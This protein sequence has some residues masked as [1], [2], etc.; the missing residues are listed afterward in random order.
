M[1]REESYLKILGFLP[2]IEAA[3]EKA[4]SLNP[5]KKIHLGILATNSKGDSKA[6]ARFSADFIADLR[7]LVNDS[8]Q[9]R[10]N[11]SRS[12]PTTGLK[13]GSPTKW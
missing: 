8:F 7:V 5:D 12:I 3:L 13:G 9:S 11:V 1:T 6:V 2:Q 10:S 4:Q